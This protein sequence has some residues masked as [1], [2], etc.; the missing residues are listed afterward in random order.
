LVRDGLTTPEEAVRVSRR[1]MAD[2]EA[3]LVVEPEAG[4]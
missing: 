3:P 2:V 4:A 1:D